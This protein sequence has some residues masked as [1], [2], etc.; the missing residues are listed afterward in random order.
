MS[1]RALVYRRGGLGD[2]LLV[3]PVLEILRKMGFHVTA[4]GN[5]DYLVLAKIV[6]WADSVLSEFPEELDQFDKKAII[7][8]DGNIPPFPEK[9]V[10]IVDYYLERLGLSG[11]EYSRRLPL[12]CSLKSKKAYLHPSSGSKLKNAPLEVF[13]EVEKFLIGKGF[14][15]LWLI[16]EAEEELKG[17]FYREI[18]VR[19][20]AELA[21]KLSCGTLFI[22]NDSGFAHLASYIGLYTIVIYG[23]SDPVVWKPV[24][25]RVHQ[26]VP[27]LNC[28]PC[29]PDVCEERDC[30]RSGYILERL[31]PLLDHI[32]VKINEDNPL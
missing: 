28:A 31:F 25:E 13:L 8:I 15:V 23:P 14:E 21:G 22:G 20:I 19:D 29:F 26:I 6:G 17:T 30:L 5:T 32:I 7:G 12:D 4:V 2:T 24:G 10:W 1:K 18:H 3:F 27:G 9:R 16:G 11:C